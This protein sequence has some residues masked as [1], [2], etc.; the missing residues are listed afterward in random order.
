M[1]DIDADVNFMDM[2]EYEMSP[3]EIATEYEN[4]DMRQFLIEN[5]ASG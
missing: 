5:G 4:D 2:D 1:I 3:L